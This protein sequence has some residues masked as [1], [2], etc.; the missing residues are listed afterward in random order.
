MGTPLNLSNTK[1]PCS[2]F[3]SA[4][5]GILY[6][7]RD[8]YLALDWPHRIVSMCHSNAAY[9][10]TMCITTR[11]MACKNK[12]NKPN[13]CIFELESFTMIRSDVM[14]SITLQMITISVL[15]LR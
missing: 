11:K 5:L 7:T 9:M 13:E 14:N 2:S 6:S 8:L 1:S 3:C 10:L 12:T 15:T 4:L